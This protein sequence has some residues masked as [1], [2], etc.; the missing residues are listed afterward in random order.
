MNDEGVRR[1]AP[2]TPGLVI[3]TILKVK[4]LKYPPPHGLAYIIGKTF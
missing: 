3:T 1:T 2:A 4:R